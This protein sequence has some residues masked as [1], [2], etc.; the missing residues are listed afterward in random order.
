MHSLIVVDLVW[1]GGGGVGE[2]MSC[3]DRLPFL[4][5]FMLNDAYL[6]C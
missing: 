1:V 2:V 4:S 3:D 5:S 6:K